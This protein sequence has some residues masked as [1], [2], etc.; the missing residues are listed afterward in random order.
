MHMASPVPVARSSQSRPSPTSKSTAASV[1]PKKLPQR[2]LHCKTTLAHHSLPLP[3]ARLTQCLSTLLTRLRPWTRCCLLQLRA[4]Q[5]SCL[6]VMRMVAMVAMGAMGP[7]EILMA[8][9]QAASTAPMMA[10]ATHNRTMTLAMDP[11]MA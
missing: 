2:Q 11:M 1:L 3:A 7:A 9:M 5:K 8:A 10:L 6:H 4:P